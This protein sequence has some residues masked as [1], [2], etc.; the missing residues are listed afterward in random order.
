MLFMSR[1]A[2]K[3]AVQEAVKDGVQNGFA[4]KGDTEGKVLTLQQKI[5]HLN[6]EVA[7]TKEELSD[8]QLRKKQELRDVE[9][10]IKIKEEKL[11]LESEKGT[12]KMQK[13]FQEK[14]QKLMAENHAAKL[15][16]LE[17]GKKDL[18]D[19]YK[20]ILHRLP[21]VNVKMTKDLNQ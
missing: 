2:F 6:E 21:N 20:E 15:A 7:K 5:V 10:M 9:H 17:Q 19:V 16:I 1:K 11:A 12:V 3:E 8:L 14:E 4:G 13:D 18:Q